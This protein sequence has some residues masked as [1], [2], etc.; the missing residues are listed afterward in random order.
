M[1]YFEIVVIN[2]VTFWMPD[3]LV[4]FL[5][6]QVYVHVH[7]VKTYESVTYYAEHFST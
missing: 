4:C 3:S 6:M 5:S 1:P 2:Y 7:F